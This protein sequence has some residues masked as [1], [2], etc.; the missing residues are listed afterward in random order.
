MSSHLGNLVGWNAPRLHGLNPIID[1]KFFLLFLVVADEF[2][3]LLF[4]FAIGMHVAIIFNF[5]DMTE[6]LVLW[7]FAVDSFQV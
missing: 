4:L 3:K 6:A 1:A 2:Q 7:E 5:N